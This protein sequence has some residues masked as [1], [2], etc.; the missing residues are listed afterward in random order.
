M[1]SQD[2]F[3]QTREIRAQSGLLFLSM[4]LNNGQKSVVTDHYDLTD[5]KM[6]SLH[7]SIF[8]FNS[9]AEKYRR[10]VSRS[11]AQFLGKRSGENE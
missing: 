6:S 2:Y 7:L 1:A 3:H 9:K 5:I 8:S 4:V 10:K 11:A